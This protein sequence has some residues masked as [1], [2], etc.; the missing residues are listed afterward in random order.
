MD[1]YR[2]KMGPR[3]GYASDPEEA[4]ARREYTR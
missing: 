4:A 3:E 1:Y 2:T